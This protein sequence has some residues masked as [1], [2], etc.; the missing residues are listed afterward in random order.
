MPEMRFHLRWPDG[1]TSAC[2]APSLVIGEYLLPGRAYPLAEF[3]QRSRAAL[4]HASE[5]VRE[6]YGFSCS[7]S[8]QQLEEIEHRASRFAGVAEAEVAVLGF[9][10]DVASSASEGSRR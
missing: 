8:L 3:L 2:Y 4:Q 10:R 5:R 9:D 1:S 7:R 6:K